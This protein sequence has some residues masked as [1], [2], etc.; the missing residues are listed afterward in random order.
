MSF[1]VSEICDIN[2]SNLSKND[3]Y[4]FIN[5]LDTANL[6]E[7][8]ISEV[9]YLKMDS[10]K[11][12]SRAKRRVKKNDI[13][14]S[15]VRPNQKHYGILRK[16]EENM[17]VSTGF[18]VLTSIEDKVNPEYLYRFLT[19]EQITQYLQAIAETSTSAY[20]SIRPGVIGDLE[21]NLPPLE[22]QAVIAN[23]LSSLDEKIET[24]N[25]INKKLEEMAQAIFKH[26]FVDFEF[27]NEDGEPYK[28]SGGDMVESE[29][30]IIPQGWEVTKINHT[31]EVTDYVAN[32]SFSALKENVKTSEEIDYAMLIRLVDYN[33][34]F[35]GPFTYV[36]E[37]GYKFLKKSKLF[38]GEIIISNVGANA[39][40]VFRAPRL[41]TPMTLGP[42]SIML[43]NNVYT[44]YLF[45]FL[46]S[47]WGQEK[48]KGI[49]GG[50][51]QP[52]FNK[53][54]FRNI[55]LVLPQKS[56]INSYNL[57]IQPIVDK[58][59]WLAKENQY[60][61]LLRDAL[62]PKLMSGEIRVPVK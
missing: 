36:N 34:N 53:T 13:L 24:N 17:I 56:V 19:Q 59:S 46:N 12:P 47:Y 14:I 61:E 48:I 33:R 39:G 6:T 1:K 18:A 37:D 43:I 50:S 25:Q 40:T 15:T 20:P 38:G 11:I 27:P 29:L 58:L 3:K 10:D 4:E 44:N 35:K 16:T 7:G 41:D 30:G 31:V 62:L 21:I 42:N 54:D 45:Y 23:I 8:I 9:Q 57:L 49:I 26:W 5:Y 28:S 55:K 2:S 51:A 22:E 32:G 52:K 60:L